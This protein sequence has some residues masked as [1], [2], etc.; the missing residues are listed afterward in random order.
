MF[1]LI[2]EL[3]LQFPPKG[4]NIR[5]YL[6]IQLSTGGIHEKGSWDVVSAVCYTIETIYLSLCT[7]TAETASPEPFSIN[8]P[9]YD[10]FL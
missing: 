9:V 3:S 10:N 7:Q 6:Y 1:T 8:S 4:P 5:R 2:N